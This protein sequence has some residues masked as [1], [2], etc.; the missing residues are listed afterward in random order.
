VAA[1]ALVEVVHYYQ[2]AKGA[3]KHLIVVEPEASA[4]HIPLT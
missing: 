1:A 4:D 2:H 3:K